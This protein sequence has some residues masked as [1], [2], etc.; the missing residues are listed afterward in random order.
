MIIKYSN[1]K[2]K[3]LDYMTFILRNSVV[4]A[5]QLQLKFQEK[6][7]HAVYRRLRK[8][9]N[10]N[11]VKHHTIAHKVGVYIGTKEA[12]NVTEANV[13]VPEAPS[14]Y[15][16]KHTLLLTDLVL[17]YELQALKYGREFSYKTEREIRY[18]AL[19][20]TPAG[21]ATVNKVNEIKDRIPDAEFIVTVN[22]NTQR[23]W[24]ELELSKKEQKRYDEKFKEKYDP[25]LSS[26]EYTA[27]WYFTDSQQIKTA[28]ETASRKLMNGDKV[29]VYD[30]PAVI[31]NDT[32]EEVL[33]DG[34]ASG[35]S[36]GQGEDRPGD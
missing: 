10:E 13:T 28:V 4:T 36:T 30:I 2:Q 24:V 7:M 3:D 5:K 23:I 8:L 19:K 25:L 14:L 32:W 9:K 22:G 34:S 21:K 31:T 16:I 12:R 35:E 6:N 1:L 27:V 26:G 11:Y 17:Y 18:E 29:K 33:P 15:T 20:N